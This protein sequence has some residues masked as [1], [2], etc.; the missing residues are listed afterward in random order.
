MDDR[1]EVASGAK[2]ASGGGRGTLQGP[3]AASSLECLSSTVREQ[4]KGEELHI[5]GNRCRSW[6]CPHC[7]KVQGPRLRARLIDRVEAWR[8]P[9]M[10]T[11]TVDPQFFESP[12]AAFKWVTEQRAIARVMKWLAPFLCG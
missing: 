4:E 5:V 9:M 3:A 6:F 7:A 1:D 10:L 11:F 8:S 2:A 12:E